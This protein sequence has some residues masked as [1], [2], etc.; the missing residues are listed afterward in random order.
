MSTKAHTKAHTVHPQR[1]L[2]IALLANCTIELLQRPLANALNERGFEADFWVGGFG[3]YRQAILDPDSALYDF[4][5]DIVLL[6]LDGEDLFPEVL[7]NPFDL[8]TDRRQQLARSRID[9]LEA[10][11]THLGKRLPQATLL[12]NTVTIPPLNTLVGLEYNSDYSVRDV[13]SG[14]N[15][16]LARLAHRSPSV[17]VVDV[18]SLVAWLGFARWRDPRLW[19][20][21]RMRWSREAIQ[22]LA[23]RYAATIAGR[24]GQMRKCLVLDLDN[25]LWGGIVGEEGVAGIKLGEEGIGLAYVEFQMELLNLYRKG[26]LLAICSKNNPA[27]ALEVL[28]SHPAMRL[29]EEHFAAMRINWEDK[30]TNLR[31]IAEELNIGLDSL[32]FVDDNPV[33]RAWVREALPEVYVPEWPDDPSDF[34]TALLEL[35][36]SHF[37]KL[38]ITE[39]D[40]R[41]GE[42]YRAQAQRRK[43]QATATSL[44][45][46]YRSLEMRATIGVADS[47][48]IPRIAQ[49]TQKTN[50]FNLTTRRYTEAEITD[51]ANSPESLVY[52]LELTDRF[53]SNGIV[54]VLIL[55]ALTKE[56]WLVDTFLLSCRV[57]GRTVENAFLGF[58]CD[59]LRAKGAKK[60]IGE[61][62]PT[63]KNAPV[64]DLYPRLGFR[65]VEQR[66]DSQLWELDL[67]RQQ[68]EIP[69]WFE[70]V[71]VS[72]GAH[73]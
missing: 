61:Y 36:V 4:A 11:T 72:E 24:L 51:L 27:D 23:E 20:L 64:A 37:H 25:I 22:A 54:G 68:V 63:A 34:K 33:E 3:Q 18:E 56:T 60:L 58:A 12:L 67:E 8:D 9:E 44:E 2:R 65:L 10:L 43:L 41:R 29:R 62:R 47:F 50:Q 21:A 35:E 30:A 6:Y 28:R 15:T 40:R 66:Q 69:E 73:A 48:T 57:M 7:E 46:F 39:E 71:L 13:I 1:G 26:I 52:W 5:P 19:Y 70:I 14:Y 42:L 49:L 32:V 45:D 53:G 59:V 55:R 17:V 16:G 38:A 31:A